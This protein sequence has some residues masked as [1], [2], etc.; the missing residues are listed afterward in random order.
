MQNSFWN[1]FRQL[2]LPV[3]VLVVMCGLS[4]VEQARAAQPATERSAVA[5]EWHP[6]EGSLVAQRENPQPYTA[7][8][9]D[10]RFTGPDGAELQVPAYWDGDR[11]FRFRAAFPSPGLWRWRTTCNDPADTGLHQQTGKVQVGA[12]TGENP[13]YR[14]GDLR[15]S[16]DKRYL[17]HADGTHTVIRDRPRD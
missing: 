5:V 8:E 13:L 15:V 1:Q 11:A 6:W 4:I 14:H 2:L 9:V 16:E 10:V 12:Y 17:V 3:L 7:I